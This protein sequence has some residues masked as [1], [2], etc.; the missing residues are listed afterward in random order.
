[1]A[2]KKNQDTTT[3]HVDSEKDPSQN[4]FYQLLKQDISW[5]SVKDVLTYEI[6]T[7]FSS[8]DEDLAEIMLKQGWVSRDQL[9]EIRQNKDAVGDS[10]GQVLV[11]RGIITNEQ[12]AE[13]K[14]AKESTGQPLYRTLMQLKMAVPQDVMDVLSTPIQLPFGNRTNDAFAQ[15][16]IDEEILNEE[17]LDAYWK[18]AQNAKTDFRHYLLNQEYITEEQYAQALAAELELPYD[19]LDEAVSIPA[20]IVRTVPPFLLRRHHALPYKIENNILYVAFRESHH[21]NDF[22]KMGLLLDVETQAVIAPRSIQAKLVEEHV[23]RDDS[24][25]AIGQEESLE[26]S[27]HITPAVELLTVIVRGIV[28]SNGTDIHVEPQKNSARVRYRVDGILHDV[29]TLD[30]TN[31]QRVIS[32]IK[33]LSGMD[34]ANRHIPQDGHLV[35]KMGDRNRNFRIST[36]PTIFGEKVAMRL[37]QSDMAFSSFEQLG[38]NREQRALLSDM[39]KLPNG[40]LVTTGPVGSGKTTTLYSCLNALDC[41]TNNIVTIEDPVEYDVTGVNQVQVNSKRGVT[42]ATGLRAILRQDPN[43]IMVGEIRDEETA[44]IA[45]RAA[46]TGSLV[47]STIHANSAATCMTSFIQLGVRPY[48]AS[49]AVAGIIFQRLIRRVCPQCKEEREASEAEKRELGLNE[50]EEVTLWTGKGCSQCLQTGYHGRTGVYE[51]LKVDDAYRQAVIDNPSLGHLKKSA[52]EAK[53]VPLRQHAT[54]L[55]LNGTTTIEEMSRIL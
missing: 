17:Q 51:M 37:V 11:D 38:M 2:K 14:K 48:M 15:W 31:T 28:K 47:L 42:F 26:D 39:L 21:V 4:T 6:P 13:A 10:I 29:M 30:K 3:E 52:R 5:R 41:F 24:D 53:M 36:I 7:P 34:I 46:M 16:L 9:E 8:S 40:L 43:V 22:N 49:L 1:M 35:M 50:D 20:K 55:V 25:L 27:D 19:T 18:E 12:L 45:V 33:S 54:E 44:E 23:P 32:R